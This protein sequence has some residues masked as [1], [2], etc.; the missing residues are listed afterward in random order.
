MMNVLVMAFVAIASASK[1][2][3]LSLAELEEARI[4]QT[5]SRSMDRAKNLI[6]SMLAQLVE[7]NANEQTN[8]QDERDMLAK[9]Q[10]EDLVCVN[11]NSTVVN[12]GEMI[13]FSETEGMLKCSQAEAE[14]G[15]LIS[16]LQFDYQTK[17]QECAAKKRSEECTCTGTCSA[18]G[19]QCGSDGEV[20]A[21]LKKDFYENTLAAQIKSSAGRQRELR[22]MAKM[23]GKIDK[24]FQEDESAEAAAQTMLAVVEGMTPVR[25]DGTDVVDIL[26]EIL[27]LSPDGEEVSS[28]LTDMRTDIL[29]EELAATTHVNNTYAD[30]Q[31]WVGYCNT[32]VGLWDAC[33]VEESSLSLQVAGQTM[34]VAKM[35]ADHVLMVQL[36]EEEKGFLEQ[37]LEGVNGIE[38]RGMN[39]TNLL[40][41][42]RFADQ[43]NQIKE[44]LQG[45]MD[46]ILEEEQEQLAILIQSNN[47]YTAAVLM[48]NAARKAASI[49][50]GMQADCQ[51]SIQTADSSKSQAITALNDGDMQ[52][53]AEYQILGELYTL[54]NS[55]MPANNG[56]ATLTELLENALPSGAGAGLIKVINLIRIQREELDAEEARQ[57][58]DVATTSKARACLEDGKSAMSLRNYI[59]ATGLRTWVETR[60]DDLREVILDAIYMN[61]PAIA[62]ST[63]ERKTEAQLIEVHD[64]SLAQAPAGAYTSA[65]FMMD[66]GK[67]FE[68]PSALWLLGQPGQSCGEVCYGMSLSCNPTGFQ[69]FNEAGSPS[70]SLE[71]MADMFSRFGVCD[72][73]PETTNAN[74]ETDPSF[75][76]CPPSEV[77]GECGR[78]RGMV[79]IPA[80]IDCDASFTDEVSGSGHMRICPCFAGE[81]QTMALPSIEA[82][83][84]VTDDG[85]D[86]LTELKLMTQNSVYKCPSPKFNN[87][88]TLSVQTNAEDHL[89]RMTTNEVEAS[90]IAAQVLEEYNE[91][92]AIRADEIPAIITV[93]NLVDKLANT[94]SPVPLLALEVVASTRGAQPIDAGP[95]GDMNMAANATEV[96]DTSVVDRILNDVI[97]NTQMKIAGLAL[98]VAA[99]Q[100]MLDMQVATR[101]TKSIDHGTA[102]N[103]R[104]EYWA[105]TQ[106]QK[107]IEEQQQAT[108]AENHQMRE[109]ERVVL[110]LCISKIDSFANIS[111]TTD[112]ELHPDEKIH[113]A[114]L[115]VLDTIQRNSSRTAEMKALIQGIIDQSAEDD[116]AELKA[117]ADTQQKISDYFALYMTW[118]AQERVAAG[119]LEAAYKEESIR[120]VNLALAQKHEIKMSR[121]FNE[122][123]GLVEEVQQMLLD[124]KNIELQY[125]TDVDMGWQAEVINELNG[126]KGKISRITAN[127]Q[128]KLDAQSTACDN[129]IQERISLRALV[130][131]AEEVEAT[132]LGRYQLQTGVRGSVEAYHKNMTY[133]RGNE[134]A[135]L[136]EIRDLIMNLT[137]IPATD[138]TFAAMHN[139]YYDGIDVTTPAGLKLFNDERARILKESLGLVC[140]HVW[141]CQEDEEGYFQAM[142]NGKSANIAGV[143]EGKYVEEA[144]CSADIST[145]GN[146]YVA[147]HPTFAC[148]TPCTQ[149]SMLLQVEGHDEPVDP[150]FHAAVVMMLAKTRVRHHFNKLSLKLLEEDE[151]RGDYA[152]RIL[153]QLDLYE[154]T[155][156]DENAAEEQAIA[157]EQ[158]REDGNRT[159]YNAAIAS[160]E[161]CQADVVH[162]SN[163]LTACNTLFQSMTDEFAKGEATR[164]AQKAT[165]DMIIG[166]LGGFEFSADD[167]VEEVEAVN[168]GAAGTQYKYDPVFDTIYGCESE[169][170]CIM[171]TPEGKNCGSDDEFPSQCSW[172]SEAMAKLN[173]AEWEECLGFVCMDGTCYA[174]KDISSI[175]NLANGHPEAEGAIS[176]QKLEQVTVD[177]S[178]VPKCVSGACKI[179]MEA[180]KA[181]NLGG[182]GG[183][184]CSNLG[185]DHYSSSPQV[186]GASSLDG[187]FPQAVAPS[188]E[189]CRGNPAWHGCE[190]PPADFLAALGLPALPGAGLP[191][192]GLPGLPGLPAGGDGG[193]PGL[194][195]RRS[196]QSGRNQVAAIEQHISHT[197]LLQSKMKIYQHK[198]MKGSNLGVSYASN[199]AMWSTARLNQHSRHHA[200]KTMNFEMPDAPK[201]VLINMEMIGDLGAGLP[202]LSADPTFLG[203]SGFMTQMAAESFCYRNGGRL[204]TIEELD[205]D[206]TRESGCNYDHMRVWSST[207][208][209]AAQNE[210]GFLTQAGSTEFKTNPIDLISGNPTYPE[211]FEKAQECTAANNGDRVVVRCCANKDPKSRSIDTCAAKEWTFNE[212]WT[213]VTCSQADLANGG[214]NVAS[215][216]TEA[217]AICKNNNAR[218][219]TLNEIEND[220]VRNKGCNVNNLR[221]WSQ[222][223]CVDYQT[224][225]VVDGTMTAAGSSAKSDIIPTEC[226]QDDQT[227]AVACC[228]DVSTDLMPLTCGR[229][230]WISKSFSQNNQ[231]CGASQF[232]NGQE[233]RSTVNGA[234]V[235][236]S[237]TLTQGE[238]EAF[239]NDNRA[240][241]CYRHELQTG[242]GAFSGCGYDMKLIWTRTQCSWK[243]MSGWLAGPGNQ[244]FRNKVTLKSKDRAQKVK[245]LVEGTENQYGWC[246]PVPP[247]TMTVDVDSRTAPEA[248]VPLPATP[249]WEEFGF[250]CI[251]G[252]SDGM[253][254]ARCCTGVKAGMN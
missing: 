60:T 100:V 152:A 242:A 118:Q 212:A 46:D 224:G 21:A 25:K 218:L 130:T 102:V 164:N 108:Y 79:G 103:T 85:S 220:A 3:E 23:Q 161:Q 87:R 187:E 235:G 49:A 243:G 204:C 181:L 64:Q 5:R 6:N 4:L 34:K 110:E 36:R 39:S 250:R 251:D 217:E 31:D 72:I 214:C 195:G 165:I 91:E 30:W 78:C 27:K 61:N 2:A 47:T 42:E 109:E 166:K 20:N 76:W 239:C 51:N 236:C 190:A 99:K 216:K 230:A 231:A 121:K 74:R 71:P 143:F 122:L 205:A 225:A 38:A 95:G 41:M 119:V 50:Q 167:A 26:T 153:T 88:H 124:F 219:C 127:G 254:R 62:N 226:T 37:I 200:T 83:Q 22:V 112:L 113:T 194:P 114:L 54:V 92:S 82:L 246:D 247:A 179:A 86:A 40:E 208:C 73:N 115:Q 182:K 8:L 210:A 186:C 176:F 238:A 234:T 17:Q 125:N 163:E 253:A 18:E 32:A 248:P 148:P 120:K 160:R 57:N 134:T 81:G 146:G 96:K 189:I 159:I 133:I 175:F 128:A 197:E 28:F 29:A 33:D 138:G 77:T 206:A 101:Q 202:G 111:A 10:N 126:A 116:V 237:G 178:N 136:D 156:W 69:Q 44:V 193:L 185:W 70:A 227:A 211:G 123:I 105:A 245:C 19:C 140:T 129:K 94:S 15:D 157:D 98:T 241:L 252:M 1:T 144:Q 203:C 137:G 233:Q 56:E 7:E 68:T 171:E 58:A 13:R 45:V 135:V 12:P 93:I 228:A 183:E 223:P 170:A 154:N 89:S 63:L 80:E 191:G 244:Q 168:T 14:A 173:C 215:T 75:V 207:P 192:A 150:L 172:T 90:D 11:T 67:S 43:A 209:D 142:C 155:L 240:R 141:S 249:S 9:Y 65:G 147:T 198:G 149:G 229:A 132:A 145:T 174:R 16:G 107:G 104:D 221:V 151:S 158:S 52:R 162:K 139:N 66:T 177:Y 53:T 59:V 106:E 55:L 35:E 184:G 232:P 84:D 201:Q 24:L 169:E 196:L 222:T 131:A 199:L 97:S 117:I 213:D 48:T 188:V 180:A